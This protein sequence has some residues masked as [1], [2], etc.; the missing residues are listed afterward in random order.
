ML[1]C[2]TWQ[3]ATNSWAQ[4]YPAKVIRYLVTDSAGGFADALGRIVAAGLTEVFG[5]QVIVENRPGAGTTIGTAIAA[6]APADGY[7]LVQ[8]SQSTTLSAT[9]YRNLSYDLV[10]DFAPVTRIGSAP[11]IV[12]VHPSLPVTSI[13]ELV[14]LAKAKPGAITYA[15]AGSGTSTHVSAEL[16]KTVAGVDMLHVPYRGGGE[17][18]NAVVGGEAPVYFAP[19]ATGLPQVR[20]GRLRPLAVTST[21]R[22]PIVPE[23]PTVAESGYP[24]F[25]FGLWFGLLAPAKTPKEIIATIRK[26]TVAALNRPDVSKRMHDIVVTPIGDPSEEFAELIKSEIEKWGK[27]IRAAGLTAN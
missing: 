27:I 11:Y 26:A 6:K 4:N 16:F 25:E 3:F 15:S 18:I 1:I 7:T 21:K 22:L 17:A 19:L 8:V 13:T 14:K 23:L 2:L 5:Q 12:V 10:R 24:G 9:L 20:S